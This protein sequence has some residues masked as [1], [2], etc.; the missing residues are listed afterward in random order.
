MVV[1]RTICPS[2]DTSD[3]FSLPDLISCCPFPLRCHP[4]A[5]AVTAA[6][7][8]WLDTNC[9]GLSPKKRAALYALK[10][11]MITA[12]CYPDAD[13][14]R[15]RV[16]ADFLIYLFHLDNISD[17]MAIQGTEQL[18]DLVMNALWFPERYMPT[19]HP[20]KEHP[21]KEPSV[22]KLTRE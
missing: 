22:A 21:I 7:D 13:E 15:F 12:H 1:A 16:V 4:K 9:P 19:H 11:G 6:S 5:E 18:A 3:C 17:K 2:A 10:C 8:R 20:R 14:E